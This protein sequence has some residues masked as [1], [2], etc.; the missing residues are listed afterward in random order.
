MSS[1]SHLFYLHNYIRY[2]Q[3]TP[4]KSAEYFKNCSS[5][6]FKLYTNIVTIV[7][8]RNVKKITLGTNG[9][10]SQG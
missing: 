1:L 9:A 8:S 4:S 6:N 2:N 7:F 3:P 10:V 5:V